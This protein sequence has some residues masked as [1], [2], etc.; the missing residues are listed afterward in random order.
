VFAQPEQLLIPLGMLVSV[1]AVG[2]WTPLAVFF[3]DETAPYERLSGTVNVAIVSR[4]STVV[5]G[6]TEG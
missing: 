2:V 3:G 1:F 5:A 4:P 6:R